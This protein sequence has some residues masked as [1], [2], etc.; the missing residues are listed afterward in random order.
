MNAFSIYRHPFTKFSQPVLLNIGNGS[1]RF[2]AN[3][4]KQISIL[5]D[6]IDKQLHQLIRRNH[7]LGA[8]L[9]VVAKTESKPAARFPFFLGDLVVLRVFGCREIRERRIETVVDDTLRQSVVVSRK[10]LGHMARFRVT[11]VVPQYARLIAPDQFVPMSVG[12]SRIFLTL[13]HA[14]IKSGTE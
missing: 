6:N 11:D 4:Q 14:R 10:N 5:A 1:V 13:R 7:L 2:R 8:F 9:L 12:I 3:I